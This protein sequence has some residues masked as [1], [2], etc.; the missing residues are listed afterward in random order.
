MTATRTSGWCGSP[1]LPIPRTRHQRRPT[2]DGLTP[3]TPSHDCNVL[4]EGEQDWHQPSDE[5]VEQY[6]TDIEVRDVEATTGDYEPRDGAEY[7]STDTGQVFLGT[8]GSWDAVDTAGE[9][10]GFCFCQHDT[11]ISW[12]NSG[13]TLTSAWPFRRRNEQH[14]PTGASDAQ[15]RTG[16]TRTQNG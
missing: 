6:D 5:N 11:G 13:T 4:N 3:K 14:P 2:T 15:K 10:P 8:G 1:E 9:T 16:R 12:E 7:Y